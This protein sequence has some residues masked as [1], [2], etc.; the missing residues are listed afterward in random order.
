MK[1]VTGSQSSSLSQ[2]KNSPVPVPTE[3]AMDVA[4]KESVLCMAI[5]DPLGI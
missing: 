4:Q 3:I 1:G 5:R 2:A